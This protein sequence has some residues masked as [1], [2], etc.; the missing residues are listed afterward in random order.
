MAF[1]IE[2][3][4]LVNLP[5]AGEFLSAR[6]R[7]FFETF[8]FPKRLNEWA[9]G[10]LALKR[11][12]S[13]ETGLPDLK[14]IEVL[15]QESGKPLLLAEGKPV[16]FAY[17]I[18]HGNGYAAAAVSREDRFL[19]IDLEKT[20]P[21]IAAWADSFF[22]PSELTS[23][24]DEFLTLLW[25]QKEALVKLLGTGLSLNSFDVRVVAG[26]AEFYGRARKIYEELGRPRVSL[27]K[28]TAPRGFVLSAA[29]G[30]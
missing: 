21:R 28:L 7:T 14:Q 22:H 12:A 10:R 17:S 8:K 24:D 4:E 16:P 26:E 2:L 6:E 30:R 15:P 3:I 1:R 18:T 23:R 13:A 11:L 25:T 27:Q 5:P 19:G 20:E 29:L 9:G